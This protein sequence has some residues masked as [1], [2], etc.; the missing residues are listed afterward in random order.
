MR[1]PCDPPRF[2]RLVIQRVHN[3]AVTVDG[4]EVASIGQGLV[5]FV[6]FSRQE[7]DAGNGLGRMAQRL[8]RLRIFD[9]AQGRLNR[10]LQDIQGEVLL[11]PQ[12]TFLGRQPPERHQAQLSYLRHP[13]PM[14]INLKNDGPMTFGLDSC[15]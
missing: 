3:A 6:G 2:M 11:I 1:R 9:D 15:D 12:I 8:I 5:A 4:R 14:V 13:S 7:P 10:S